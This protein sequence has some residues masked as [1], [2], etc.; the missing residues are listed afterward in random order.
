MIFAALLVLS[1]VNEAILVWAKNSNGT[2]IRTFSNFNLLHGR[3]TLLP[4]I[5]LLR[6]YALLA[7]W[8]IPHPFTGY[9][10]YIV[11]LGIAVGS[12][13]IQYQLFQVSHIPSLCFDHAH[14]SQRMYVPSNTSLHSVPK[15]CLFTKLALPWPENCLMFPYLRSICGTWYTMQCIYGVTQLRW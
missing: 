14:C 13:H 15:W 12:S 5:P 6:H 1:S 11:G 4:F 9:L 7:A 3:C 10:P 2:T 8:D